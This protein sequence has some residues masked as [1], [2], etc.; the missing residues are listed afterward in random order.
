M[1]L[2]D[3]VIFI[4]GTNR[5]IGQQLVEAA[6]KH[7]PK[8]VY[9]AARDVLKLNFTDSRVVP[10]KLDITDRAQ[11]DAAVKSAGDVDLLLNSAGVLSPGSVLTGTSENLHRDME[12]N[13]FGTLFLTQAFL[14]IIKAN[15]GGIAIISSILGKGPMN[16]IGGY[17][18]SKAALFSAIT[19]MRAELQNE[20]VSVFGI[21]PGPND[22]AMGRGIPVPLANP[23]V[24]AETI[25]SGIVAGDEDI[26]PDM[27]AQQLSQLWSSDP[28]QLERQ[29]AK[30]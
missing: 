16:A 3:K 21:F 9:A 5:G 13:Y 22:T 17:S 6:L 20:G 1:Q 30:M 27:I 12:V 4:T 28:K 23:T 25:F 8:K 2:K 18:A 26:Y 11:I 10:V 15:K 29:L 7:N 24:T 19:S 14:P